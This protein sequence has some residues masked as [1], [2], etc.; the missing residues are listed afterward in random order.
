MLLLAGAGFFDK[1]SRPLIVGSLVAVLAVFGFL[2]SILNDNY[3]YL[4]PMLVFMLPLGTLSAQIWASRFGRGP[5]VSPAPTGSAPPD[6]TTR[7]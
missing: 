4:V 7:R 2:A 1:R 3:R 6:F 5:L